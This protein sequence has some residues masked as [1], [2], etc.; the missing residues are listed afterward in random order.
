MDF[1]AGVILVII[2]I[3]L[4]IAHDY[5]YKKA[6]KSIAF[7]NIKYHMESMCFRPFAYEDENI[8]L[9]EANSMSIYKR[10]EGNDPKDF[11]R[12]DLRISNSGYLFLLAK[13]GVNT[14]Y[15]K[16]TIEAALILSDR[17]IRNWMSSVLPIEYIHAVH[18]VENIMGETR[19]SPHGAPPIEQEV[20]NMIPKALP[21]NDKGVELLLCAQN[22]LDAWEKGGAKE[23]FI[24]HVEKMEELTRNT[25]KWRAYID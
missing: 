23:S 2:A 11:I 21:L 13:G 15:H 6:L 17:E 1:I 16:N 5:S 10:A 22:M 12:E 18:F 19:Q 8:Y 20:R 14:I 4:K 9:S 3:V 25:G 24:E 7:D